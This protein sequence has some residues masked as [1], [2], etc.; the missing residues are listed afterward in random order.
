MGSDPLPLLWLCG[1]SGVGKSSLG[2]EV[3]AQL[4]R[5]G[6]R[7]AFLDA[8][9]ISLCY[10]LPESGTHRI[11]ARSLAAMWPNF[12]EQGA[13]C[14]VLSGFVDTAEEI[15]EYAERLPDAAFTLCR[16]RVST[17]ELKERFLARG[18]RP[19]LVAEAV[20]EAA[21]L[22][23]SDFADLCLDTSGLTVSEA[24][25][26]V[27]ERAGG[28]P[29]P[30]PS[31]GFVSRPA[32]PLVFDPV[33]VLWFS[34]ATAVGKSTVGYE[35]FSQIVRTGVRAAYVDLKQIGALRPTADDDPDGHR[36][37]ARN[38]A[39][40]WAGYRAAQARCLIVSGHADRD[41]TVRDYAELLPGAGLTVCRL[42][43]GPAT[44]A[45][46]VMR[47]G[48]GGGPAIPGDELKGLRPEALHSVAERAAREAS[49]LDIAG[50]GDLRI[51]TD[52]RSAREVA[53]EVRALIGDWPN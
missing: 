12:R 34:G 4:S 2:W 3:F 20:A 50:A 10:P 25:R 36:L 37:K 53:E 39:A 52:D 35:V 43:A 7:A 22:E 8:D 14:V 5:G 31:A 40:L 38:L 41:D 13:Q 27:R 9:Q 46:R 45:E 28:W 18:W 42:H 21:A 48:R 32:V 26:M 49:A 30:G 6:V 23:R 51:D 47:R 19:D 11:R 17:G 33:P 24:A 29:R 44:L 1:P 16:L 15:R